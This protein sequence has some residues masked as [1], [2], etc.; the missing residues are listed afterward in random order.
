MF[1]DITWSLVILLVFFC[2]YSVWLAVR[3]EC[4]FV[5]YCTTHLVPIAIFQ[6]CQYGSA[7]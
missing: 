6:V 5:L 3:F 7:T 4:K 1:S 2:E